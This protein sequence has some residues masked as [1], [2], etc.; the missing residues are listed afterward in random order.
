MPDSSSSSAFSR[1]RSSRVSAG[2]ICAGCACSEATAIKAALE[3]LLGSQP[4]FRLLPHDFEAHD[5]FTIITALS[6]EACGFAKRGE[7]LRLAAEGCI[8]PGG[9]IPISTFGGLK[10]RGHPVGASGAYQIVE[11]A[12]QLRGEGGENQVKGAR[13]ALA[14]S[15][16]G[17]GSVA[18]THILEA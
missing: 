16:G 14:Q 13:R 18:V 17:H 8:A 6:L 1:A 4:R 15:V 12:L 10:A 5:A 3:P 9:C 11:A 7:A 2:S